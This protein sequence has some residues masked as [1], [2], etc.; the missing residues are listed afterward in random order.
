[1]GWPLVPCHAL[2]VF[3]AQA[4]KGTA[5]ASFARHEGIAQADVLAVGDDTNDIT[6][7]RWAGHGVAMPHA[8]AETAS[9]ADVQLAADGRPH[10]ELLADYLIRAAS[11]AEGGLDSSG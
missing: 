7:L 4:H 11:L 10:T 8:N 3:Q 5:L 1:V 2:E 6:M 9:A